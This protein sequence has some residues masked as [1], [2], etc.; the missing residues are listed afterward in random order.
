MWSCERFWLL[1]V[2]I[3][4]LVTVEQL[5]SVKRVLSSG[6]QFATQTRHHHRVGS[7][8]EMPLS[9]SLL[10]LQVASSDAIVIEPQCCQS[11]CL[12]LKSLD[13]PTPRPSRRP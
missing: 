3:G 8:F 11:L 7:V 6:C 2:S 12:L 9:K 5:S 10:S 1:A 4:V 13:A